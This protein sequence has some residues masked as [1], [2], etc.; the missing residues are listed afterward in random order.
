VSQATDDF[1]CASRWLPERLL[2]V[3]GRRIYHCTVT[4]VLIRPQEATANQ[5]VDLATVK[6]NSET[7]E[8]SSTSRPI[9][10]HALC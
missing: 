2:D 10:P 9:T 7:A 6:F 1:C 4:V 3:L 8:A 5:C